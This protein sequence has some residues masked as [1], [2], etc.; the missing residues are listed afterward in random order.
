MAE[1]TC[2]QCG[3]TFQV[4]TYR[5]STAKYCSKDCHL[6]AQRKDQVECT[7]KICGKPFWIRASKIKRGWG[8]YCSHECR[9]RSNVTRIERTCKVC[10][11]K[12]MVPKSWPKFGRGETCSRA[13]QDKHQESLCGPKSHAWRGGKSFEPYCP[14]FNREFKERVR[15][16]WGRKCGICGAS[17]IGRKLHVHHVNYDK[18]TC[19]NDNIPLFIPLCH[20]H[21]SMTNNGDR[22]EWALFFTRLIGDVSNG[23][24][25]CYYSRP[26]MAAV[27]KSVI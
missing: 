6:A 7:C 23:S 2:Q 11:K 13:C 22:D 8:K 1:C 16:Y 4:R 25:E 10:G 26:E 24:M 5:A 21:H 15:E 17:E 9:G 3:K 19:C 14:L 12:F 18:E 20:R 27:M